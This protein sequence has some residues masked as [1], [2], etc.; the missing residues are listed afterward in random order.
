MTGPGSTSGESG[1]PEQPPPNPYAPIDYPE[2]PPGYPPP[3]PGP[4]GYPPP[5]AGYPPAPPGYPPPYP[6]PP[7]YPAYPG[8]YDPYRPVAQSGTN[9]MAIGS[10]ICSLAGLFTC[11]VTAIV[12]VILGLVAMQQVKTTGQE[13][14]GMAL[15]GVIVGAVVIALI[16]LLFFAGFLGAINDSRT[17]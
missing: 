17:Y 8:G 10:L 9:G 4:P 13:G 7:A 11:G 6:G 15:A 2:Y 16:A 3:P 12:G 14:R 5:P 1:Y